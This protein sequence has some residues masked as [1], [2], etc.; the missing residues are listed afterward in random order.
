MIPEERNKGIGSA[1]AKFV[2]TLA[3]RLGYNTLY[4]Y[5]SNENV[6]W[7]VKKGAFVFEKRPFHNHMI[8]IM[9]VPLQ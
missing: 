5:T 2:V 8:T 9:Q 6:E 7:C 3:K 4:F 1:L